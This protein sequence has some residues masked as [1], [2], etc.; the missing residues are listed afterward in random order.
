[1]HLQNC[2]SNYS[3]IKK[4]FVFEIKII[5][6]EFVKFKLHSVCLR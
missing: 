6:I 3:I 1:M 4:D 2:T 5:D